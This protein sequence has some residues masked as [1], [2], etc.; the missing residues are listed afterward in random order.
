MDSRENMLEWT[1][2]MT[3]RQ[4]AH[5]LMTKGFVAA[6]L[7]D[8]E[9]KRKD[10]KLTRAREYL[11]KKDKALVRAHELAEGLDIISVADCDLMQKALALTLGD[12]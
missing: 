5:C 8:A 12:E 2:P 7:F 3:S 9:M 11:A 6:E 1:S 10:R 4:A